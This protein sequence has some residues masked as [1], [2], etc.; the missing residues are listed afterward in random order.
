MIRRKKLF[1]LAAAGT[2]VL[3]ACGSD[4]DS[5]SDT[6]GAARAPRRRPAPTLRRHRGTG[7]HRGTCRHRGARGTEAPDGT[8]APAGGEAFAVDTSAC[9]DPD[10]ATAPIEG[11]IKIG[12]S[13]PL[14]GGPAVLFAPFGAGMQAYI[15]YYNTEIGGVNGQQLELVI[16][17]DQYTADLTKPNVDELIFDDE[18][19]AARRHHR[20]GEQPGRPGRPQR[21]V[22]P[23][24]VRRD[25]C[26]RTG[27]T[28]RTTRGPPVC[29]FRTTSRPEVWAQYVAETYGEG[30]TVAMF[31]V[32][33]E[34][35]LPT[36]TRS[37]RP[38]RRTGSR[39]WR[40]GVDR[41]SRLRCP[42][43]SDDQHRRRGP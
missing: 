7:R 27:V 5:S 8:E 37:P 15:D 26:H 21:P 38:P 30:A 6:T 32:N 35:G 3:A 18:V 22:H 2:L 13:I 4:D 14:S 42:E 10:A 23:A 20:L 17:D 29:S 39:S 36:S 11:T 12:T 33:N 1:A 34:F 9:D 41:G 28:S 31:T 24:A 19:V 25:R 16:K 43:W 40:P